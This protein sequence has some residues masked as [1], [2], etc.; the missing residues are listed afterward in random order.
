MK[1]KIRAEENALF[2]WNLD[3]ARTS[4]INGEELQALVD[5]ANGGE[6]GFAKRLLSSG[7]V[8]E[9]DK[10][11]ILQEAIAASKR[12]A[13]DKSFCAPESLH[14]ELTARCALHCPQCYKDLSKEDLS[15][16]LLEE[17]LKQ[18]DEMSV[19]QIAFGGGEPLLYPFLKEA[20]QLT[21][22]L[23]MSCSV[24]TSGYGL[25][26]EFLHQLIHMGLKHIQISLNGST[27]EI[28][29]QSR[30][31]FNYA[32]QALTLL[33][34]TGI[35]YGINWVARIDNIHDFPFLISL[36]RKYKAQN[37]NILRYKPSQREN[38]KE[39][40]LSPEKVRFLVDTIRQTKGIV[41]KVDSAFSNLLCYL[42]QK[43]AIFSGCGAGRRFLAVDANG[44][45]RPCSHI[46]MKEK[47]GNLKDIWYHSENLSMFREIEN[48]I[49]KPCKNCAFLHGCEGC[50]AIA[51][52]G[53]QDFYAGDSDCAFYQTIQ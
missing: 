23:G 32:I 44:E 52:A 29:E 2:I 40:S 12:K 15:F 8:K 50:R 33:Q 6:N 13:P 53:N 42:N 46:D 25:N 43:P 37:I 17:I 7:I 34:E 38:F 4:Y 36:A 22:S 27:K 16:P 39:T 51:K 47:M 10:K 19:F 3:N 11:D 28:H 31:G 9:E 21:S 18:A 5:W 35:S 14:I 45:I 41:L 48:K 49:K 1:N 30:D 26:E 24:T 20:I